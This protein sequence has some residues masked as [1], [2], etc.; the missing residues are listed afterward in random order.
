MDTK[1]FDHVTL[2]LMFDLLIINFNQGYNFQMVCTR[3]LGCWYF[4]ECS[5]WQDLFMGTKIF[6]LDIWPTYLAY[7]FWMVC[8]RA[9]EFHM[10]I[11]YGKT[12]PWVPNVLTLWPWSLTYLLKTLTLAITFKW[13]VLGCWYFM[14]VLCDKIFSWGPKLLTLWPWSLTY[15]LKTF[16]LPITFEWYVLGLWYF[17]WVFLMARPF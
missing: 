1:L 10:S 9:L 15:L 5:L 8:T 17:T 14:S 16:S 4:N 7:I 6:D 12:C 13:Y 3:S 2:T 11:P